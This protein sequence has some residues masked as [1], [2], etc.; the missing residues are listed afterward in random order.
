MTVKGSQLNRAAYDVRHAFPNLVL[1]AFCFAAL[2]L[3]P[4]R[5]QLYPEERGTLLV[6]TLWN[7]YNVVILGAAVMVA[8]E[9]PQRR[10]TWRVRREHRVRIL[11]EDTRSCTASPWT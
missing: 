11:A 9:R 10:R 1:L 3:T 4:S 6:T 7:V 5:W 8:L 2:V